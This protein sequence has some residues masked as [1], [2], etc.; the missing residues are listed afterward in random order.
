MRQTFQP[1]GIA[2]LTGGIMA[3]S[4]F[5]PVLG[6]ATA[7]A[8]EKTERRSR[9]YK[10]GA[11][12]LGA[13]AAYFALKSKK[14]VPAAI[15]GAGAYYAYKKSQDLKNKSERNRYGYNPDDNQYPVGD[16]DDY[17]TNNRDDYDA[18][19]ATY[20]DDN[21]T[22]DNGGDYADS[23]DYR[24]ENRN[25]DVQIGDIIPG[26]PDYSSRTVAPKYR[27]GAK[28]TVK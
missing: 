1:R 22:Y 6:V 20:P 26:F 8:D 11:I 19:P 16:N 5:F 24:D 27:R 9:Q 10:T 13:A 12:V 21:G 15:A 7:R 2:L 3:V 17:G 18:E 25:R 14:T 4:V 23:G 28:I